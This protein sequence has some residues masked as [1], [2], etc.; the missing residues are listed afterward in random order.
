MFLQSRNCLSRLA[1]LPLT[2]LLVATAGC[3]SS[4]V[5]TGIPTNASAGPAFVVGTDAPL[6]S[7]V[8][9]Q[10]QIQSIVLSDSNG[11]TANLLASPATVDF[12]RYN[13]LQGLVDMNDVPAGTYTAV[14]IQL[15]TASIGYLD[16]TSTAP[17]IVTKSA[18]LTTSTV[19]ITLNHPLTV[20]SKSS[21]GAPVGL[22]MDLDLAQSVQT[23]NG[24]ITGTV[25]PTFDVTTVARTDT[26][27]HIDEYTGAVI[28]PPSGSTEPSSFVIEGPH[29]ERF[30]IDTTSATEW[31]DNGSLS[32]LNTNSVVTVAGQLDPADQTLDA[33]EVAIVSDKGFYAGGL[34]TYVSPAS[35]QAGYFDFYVRSL[36]PES[37]AMQLGD[38][39]QVNLTGSETYGIYWMHN[40]FTQLLFNSSALVPGQEIMVGGQASDETSLNALKVNRINL[41]EWGY[42]GSI[43]P[44]SLNAGQGTFQLQ[45]TGFAGVVIPSTITVYLGPAADF[46]YGLDS[47]E[48]LSG[49]VKVRVVGLLL[50]NPASGQLVL[51]ARHVDGLVHTDTT[52]TA[53]Q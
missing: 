49:G 19:N 26:G 28:T 7:V 47:I 43:V 21:G 4:M 30:T 2:A 11:N 40:A 51:L 17:A 8:S 37:T 32:A 39:A 46:R 42:E 23:N 10:L 16:T 36:L 15:G 34:V 25:D 48:G 6:A 18:T 27:A 33:D 9:L 20:T 53:W 41:H 14:T 44:G 1:L 31:D 45:V 52:V 29:G 35:G 50:K 5:A 13:G 12:A 24:A 22:R 3:G 38:I